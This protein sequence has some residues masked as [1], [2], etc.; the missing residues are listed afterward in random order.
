MF[1]KHKQHKAQVAAER[2]AQAAERAAQEAA[3]AATQIDALLGWCIDRTRE[4][5]EQP[6][7]GPS[8]SLPLKAGERAVYELTGA[9]LVEPRRGSGHWQSGTQGVS[10][11]IPG[12]RTARYRVGSTRGHYVQGE[13][14]PTVIDTGTL[15]ITTKRAV[16]L[17]SKQSREWQWTK[18]TGIHDE[19]GVA[20]TSIG[21]S[22]R[23]KVS[24]IAY[25]TERATEV[26][27]YLE[28]AAAAA[29]GTTAQM[30][31]EL[32]D[33]RSKLV[34]PAGDT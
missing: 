15:T 33:E 8:V 32:Q 34:L 5:I 3:R 10:V 16:F 17:G 31:A 1:E 4:L 21:V 28:L 27:F 6:S 9:Q 25:P 18:L 30:L 26:R 11:R 23:Q 24:G 22:N 7:S 12:T 2:T 20:W 29:N 13:E 19:P 14:K